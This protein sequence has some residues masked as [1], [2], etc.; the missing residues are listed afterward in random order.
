MTQ[1]QKTIPVVPSKKTANFPFVV[2]GRNT[3]NWNTVE[4]AV[5]L[6]AAMESAQALAAKYPALPVRIEHCQGGPAPVHT[7]PLFKHREGDERPYRHALWSGKGEPPA[8]GAPVT[9]TANAIGLGKV[10]GYAVHGGYLGVMVQADDA[11]R[12]AWHKAQNPE[13]TPMLVF[14]AELK[15][16]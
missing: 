14:G 4:T 3:E 7:C 10:T 16:D 6:E 9:I 11:T 1:A 8:L 13:N 5:T 15:A 2:Q 12:P